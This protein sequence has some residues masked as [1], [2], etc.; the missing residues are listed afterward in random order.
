M[1]KSKVILTGLFRHNPDVNFDKDVPSSWLD[2]V[3]ESGGT[4]LEYLIKS[5]AVNGMTN[6][7]L[8]D[9]FISLTDQL[10]EDFIRVS[11][12][13]D[14]TFVAMGNKKKI[15]DNKMHQ[16]TCYLGITFIKLN[17]KKII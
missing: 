10:I 12:V 16:S 3:S 5:W 14:L 11:P 17:E 2:I 6:D 4:Y 15:L 7:K 1:N 13:N 8:R 9:E